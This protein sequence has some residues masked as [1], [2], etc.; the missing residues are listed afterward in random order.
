MF[1]QDFLE[2]YTLSYFPG[3]WSSKSSLNRY[4]QNIYSLLK[5]R[6]IAHLQKRVEIGEIS[7]GKVREIVNLTVQMKKPC[8]PPYL[9][10]DEESLLIAPAGIEG[11]H[12]LPL[13]C[14]GVAIQFQ[15][16]VNAVKTRCVYNNILQKSSMRYLQV[17]IKRVNKKE[18]EHEDQRI[19]N[20]YRVSKGI[21]LDQQK[22]FTE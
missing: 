7:P 8:Q 12:G 19:K 14:H 6:N 5:S 9:N 21:E 11:G 18:D 15:N 17:V 1:S 16:V 3:I 10:E 2:N 13:D 4:L 20:S 22:S